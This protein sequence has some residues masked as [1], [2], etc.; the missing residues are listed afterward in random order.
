MHEKF[1]LGFDQDKKS[2]L[3]IFAAA[4]IFSFSRYYLQFRGCQ[5]CNF[6]QQFCEFEVASFRGCKLMSKRA[7]LKL[8]SLKNDEALRKGGMPI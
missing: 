8:P 4:G 1:N 5:R 2:S 3:L 7:F 6:V